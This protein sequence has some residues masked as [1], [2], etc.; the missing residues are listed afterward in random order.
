MEDAMASVLSFV[1]IGVVVTSFVALMG[2]VIRDFISN[3]RDEEGPD[4]WVEGEIQYWASVA[5]LEQEI[6]TRRA[7]SAL[8]LAEKESLQKE[9]TR[10]AASMLLGAEK[11]S[12]QIVAQKI[13]SIREAETRWAAYKYLSISIENGG[14]KIERYYVRKALPL[15]IAR[16]GKKGLGL[17]TTLRWAGCRI[18]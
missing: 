17:F 4:G 2:Q 3:L 16:E 1:I 15:W 10:K 6:S 18:V 7:A 11:K 13:L 12:G 5:R 14:E 9:G 8:R